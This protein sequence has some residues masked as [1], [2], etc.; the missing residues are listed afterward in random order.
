MSLILLRHFWNWYV[1]DLKSHGLWVFI[2]SDLLVLGFMMCGWHEHWICSYFPTFFGVEALIQYR[3]WWGGLLITIPLALSF[4]SGHFQMSLYVFGFV[5]YYLLIRGWYL[6]RFAEMFYALFFLILSIF[7]VMPQLYI[8][9]KSFIESVRSVSFGSGEIIP[10]KYLSTLFAPDFY[11]NPVTRNDWFGHYAEWSSY[12]GI[13]SLVLAVSA[14]FTKKRESLLYFGIPAAVALLLATPSPLSWALYWFKVP[15]LSTSAASRIVVL[16]SFSLS[17]LASFG[18]D[19][20]HESWK[21][22]KA[23]MS[24]KQSVSVFAVV[25]GLFFVT[26]FLLYG[27][28]DK[29]QIALRNSIFSFV[30]LGLSFLFIFLGRFTKHTYQRTLISFCVV[31]LVILDMA[32]FSKKWM[33]FDPPEL[34]YPQMKVLTY[35]SSL[36]GIDRVFGNYG[37]ELSTAFHIPGIEGYDAL[38]KKRYGEFLQASSNGFLSLP[39]RSVAAMDK[40]GKFEKYYRFRVYTAEK[41]DEEMSGVSVLELAEQYIRVYE[42]EHYESYEN[43]NA[44]PGLFSFPEIHS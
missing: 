32:K 38:Y 37:N 44:Y 20:W 6:K 15:V 8:T 29:L 40:N 11:G 3:R 34:V 24:L 2:S 26:I 17:V 4:L 41:S 12:I 35:L 39:G 27:T 19:E 31:L 30:L 25:S 10:W 43:R 23:F 1:F 16:F 36:N 5:F 9:Y 22:K 7:V 13:V 42:D 18:W 21:S 28:G 14:F 33:P